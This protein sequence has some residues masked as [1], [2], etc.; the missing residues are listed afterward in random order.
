M[1]IM[2]ATVGSFGVTIAMVWLIIAAIRLLVPAWRSTAG[3]HGGRA[4]IARLVA[5]AAFSF[6]STQVYRNL[7]FSNWTEMID[8]FRTD[9]DAG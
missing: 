6:G 1:F 7:G 5:V 8:H 9:M 3:W 2:L 4:A